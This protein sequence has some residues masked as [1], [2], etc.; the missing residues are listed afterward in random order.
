[1]EFFVCSNGWTA[2]NASVPAQQWVHLVGVRDGEGL[3]LYVGVDLVAECA[4]TGSVSSNSFAPGVG[5]DQQTGRSLRGVPAG[6]QIY[7]RAL[8]ASEIASMTMSSVLSGAIVA[9]DFSKAES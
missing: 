5:V 8:N 1:M 4:F 2:L 7:S 6:I 9:Y 3:K